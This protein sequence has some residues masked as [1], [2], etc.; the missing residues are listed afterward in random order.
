MSGSSNRLYGSNSIAHPVEIVGRKE[1][2]KN[3]HVREGEPIGPR[4]PRTTMQQDADIPPRM[5][6]QP[7]D[8]AAI[9]IKRNRAPVWPFATMSMCEKVVKLLAEDEFVRER[10]GRIHPSTEKRG[11]GFHHERRL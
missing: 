5:P 7:I 6:K 1:L 4:T 11:K 9:K 10:G 3:V 2:P 8:H